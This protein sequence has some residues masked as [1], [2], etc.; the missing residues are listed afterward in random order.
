MVLDHKKKELV[1]PIGIEDREA[2]LCFFD[3]DRL[4]ASLT[5]I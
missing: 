5:A 4:R 1:I 2:F 3:V